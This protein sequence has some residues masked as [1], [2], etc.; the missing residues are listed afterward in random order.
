MNNYTHKTD[1]ELFDLIKALDNDALNMLFKRHYTSLCYFVYK[2]TNNQMDAEE[3]VTDLFLKIWQNSH[4]ININK[5]VKLYLFI[6]A[7]NSSI[8]FLKKQNRTSF[9]EDFEEDRYSNNSSA[10]ELL[11]VLDLKKSLELLLQKLPPKREIIFRLN[12][13]DGFGYKEIAQM[14]SISVNTVQNQMVKAV[15]FLTQYYSTFQ[16]K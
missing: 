6:S 9:F 10:D 2:F 3:I 13:F 16:K 14:L 8:N 12:R 5:N 15:Q 1:I 11:N 7:K 4:K